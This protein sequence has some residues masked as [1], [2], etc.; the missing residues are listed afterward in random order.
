[1]FQE[2]A[3]CKLCVCVCVCVCLCFKKSRKVILGCLGH[4]SRSPWRRVELPS[5]RQ[6]RAPL[7]GRERAASV[8]GLVAEEGRKEGKAQGYGRTCANE[9]PRATLDE[10]VPFCFAILNVGSGSSCCSGLV[11]LALSLSLSLTVRD[12]HRLEQLKQLIG[13][14]NRGFFCS[15]YVRYA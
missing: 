6:D 3:N 10:K 5:P 13:S 12:V 4:A 1:M 7:D 8:L 11:I 2:A 14:P 15:R 9:P